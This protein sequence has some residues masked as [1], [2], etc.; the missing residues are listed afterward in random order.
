[1]YRKMTDPLVNLILLVWLLG[2]VHL[3]IE[4]TPP[5]VQA[6]TV[7]IDGRTVPYYGMTK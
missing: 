6:A 5:P 1:M 2:F 4:T 3:Y 7:M